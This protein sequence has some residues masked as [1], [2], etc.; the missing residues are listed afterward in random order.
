[1]VLKVRSRIRLHTPP[2]KKNLHKNKEG[3]THPQHTQRVG[4]KKGKEKK[5][6]C[7]RQ[8]FMVVLCWFGLVTGVR[9]QI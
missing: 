6:S 5:Q 9:C 4:E 2:P 7:R 8:D 1:M 3:N